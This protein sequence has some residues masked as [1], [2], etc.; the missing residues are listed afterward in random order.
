VDA[1]LPRDVRDPLTPPAIAFGQ[2]AWI[3]TGPLVGAIFPL[4]II[5]F[6][7]PRRGIVLAS[8]SDLTGA[9]VRGPDRRVMTTSATRRSTRSG[10]SDHALFLFSGTFFPIDQLPDNPGSRGSC[11]CGTG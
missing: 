1:A 5:A 6:G 2:I 11:R 3:A 9:R 8:R 4:V 10:G 7:R